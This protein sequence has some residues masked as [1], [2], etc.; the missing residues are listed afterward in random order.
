MKR[1]KKLVLLSHCILNQNS[2]VYP[3]ARAKGA[4]S[5]VIYDYLHHDYGL[6]QLPCPELKYMGMKRNPM[7]KE[8]YDTDI[9]R[10]ICQDLVIDVINDLKE[11][12]DYGVEIDVLHGINQSP[13]CSITGNRGH[14]ITYLIEQLN[15]NDFKLKFNEIPSD[16]EE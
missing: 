10:E 16:Y 13:T 5:K 8:D 1:H 11:Y 15:A 7:S 14:F 9:Y 6:Y 12:R 4:F 2:V 3:L